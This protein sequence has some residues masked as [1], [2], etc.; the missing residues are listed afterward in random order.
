M[1]IPSP[2]ELASSMQVNTSVNIDQTFVN[3]Q[4]ELQEEAQFEVCGLMFDPYI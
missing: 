2:L 3:C 1:P 4:V